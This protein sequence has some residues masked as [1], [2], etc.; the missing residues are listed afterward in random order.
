MTTSLSWLKRDWDSRACLT[1]VRVHFL[2]SSWI[3]SRFFN[4]D[5]DIIFWSWLREAVISSPCNI[6]II[7][8]NQITIIKQ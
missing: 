3:I 8:N 2:P 7:I 5:S 6:V 1:S 4:L